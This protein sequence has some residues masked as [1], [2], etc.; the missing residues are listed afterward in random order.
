[1]NI[2]ISV[3]GNGSEPLF[4][5]R[6]GRAAACCLVNTDTGDRKVHENP[7][8]SAAGG[9]GVKAAQFI[10]SLGV[11]VVISG[12]YG[13]NAFRTLT[14]AGIGMYLMPG[15]EV[16]SVSNVLAQFNAGK[17]DRA[18]SATHAGHHGS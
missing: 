15:S 18:E 5:P 6:F 11:Q 7:A 4:D 17:L 9:A 13:P 16:L 8:L 14:S 10:A 2:A 1:M 12:A 3:T